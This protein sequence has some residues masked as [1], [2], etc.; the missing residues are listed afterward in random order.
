MSTLRGDL[1]RGWGGKVAVPENAVKREQ[2]KWLGER[3]GEEELYLRMGNLRML[4]KDEDTGGRGQ[5][6]QREEECTEPVPEWGWKM[7]AD[8]E[9]EHLRALFP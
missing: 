4:A 7:G 6:C 2:G 5:V 9:E 1:G 3:K 8:T